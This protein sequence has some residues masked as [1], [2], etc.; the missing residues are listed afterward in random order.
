M[1]DAYLSR[2]WLRRDAPVAA[3]RRLLVPD[4]PGARTAAAHRLVW[5]LFADDPDRDRDF[6]WREGE[7]GSFYLLSARPPEDRHGL[8]RVDP[9][10]PFAPTL[11]PGDRL[12]FVLRANATVARK[13]AGK[14]AANGRTRGGRCDVVMD[15]LHGVPE[16]DRARRR[17]ELLDPVA[18]EWM[19]RQG[20]AHGF[21]PDLPP[22]DADA[23][24]DAAAHGWTR[25]SGYRV[26]QVDRGPRT[27]PM[28]AGVLDIE[29][30]LTVRDPARFL[31]AVGRGF[32]R[33][34]AFGCGLMLVRRA[35]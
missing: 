29:G 16:G 6:L 28:R 21:A 8:F 5:T 9:P 23:E 15:A 34:R 22:H 7:P 13:A 30:T 26:L 20:E 17:A 3:L 19:V 14:A 4:E 10:K 18:R 12:A 11:A 33:A 31:A 1:S 24:D 27:P 2:V 32:G 35:R 25:A